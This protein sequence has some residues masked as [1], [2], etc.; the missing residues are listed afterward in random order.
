MNFNIWGSRSVRHN[1]LYTFY[2]SNMNDRLSEL[3]RDQQLQYCVYG[4]H[5]YQLLILIFVLDTVKNLLFAI[6]LKI[7]FY[8]H[9]ES[10]LNGIME[11]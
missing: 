6:N 8:H 1:D 10:V 2:H 9:A 4:D 5:I 11:I 3:Q 7:G